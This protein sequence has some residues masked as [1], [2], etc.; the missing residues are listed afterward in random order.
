M[1]YSLN[2]KVRVALDRAYFH[3]KNPACS[4]CIKENAIGTIVGMPYTENGRRYEVEFVINKYMSVSFLF[5]SHDLK[6]NKI[7]GK[8]QQG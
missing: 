2:E 8:I 4:F 3:F 7:T 6:K 5:A 1:E